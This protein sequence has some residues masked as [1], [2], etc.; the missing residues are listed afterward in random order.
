MKYIYHLKPEPFEGTLLIPLNQM[1]KESSIYANHAK[2]YVGRESLMNEMIPL[3]NCKWNDVVQ[4]SSLDPQI[5]LNKLIEIF[6]DTKIKRSEYFKIPIQDVLTNH[7]VALFK[8]NPEKEKGNFKIH[9]DE[10]EFLSLKNYF[11]IKEVPT[12]TIQYWEETKMKNGNPLWFPFIPH[13]FVK[14]VVETNH[15][16]ICELKTP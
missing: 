16:E 15:C 2:K 3:L 1:D 11:E 7:E 8:R 5:L 10:I 14:G 4:F 12:K 9:L 13:V 6:P